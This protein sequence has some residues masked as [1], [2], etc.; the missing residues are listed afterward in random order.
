MKSI[1]ITTFSFILFSSSLFGQST[2]NA[3]EYMDYFSADYATLQADMW[4][5]TRTV[6]HG[7]SARKVEKKRLEMIKTSEIAYKR[8]KA[9][10]DYKG[11][12]E[13]RDTVTEYFRI[14]NLVL[15]EDYSKLVD[16]ED[17][18]EQSYDLMEAYMTA[19]ELASD[20]Q[21]EAAETVSRVQARF[22]KEN[23]ITLLESSDE[24]S[25]KMK[26]AG[27]VYDHYNEVYLIF[28]KSNKQELYLMNAISSGDVNAIEQNREALK[29][30]LEEGYE[31]LKATTPYNGDKTMVE[32]TK[33]I[34]DFYMKEATEGAEIVVNYFLASENFQKTK[35]SFDQIKE[36]SRTQKDID[37]FNE[38]V[39][40]MNEAVN[41]FNKQNTEFNETRSALIDNWN[42][43]AENF[44]HK[45]V[46]RKK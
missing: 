10:S 44:T 27:E 14:I 8:A 17:V 32:A 21:S 43:S 35:N 7:K 33:K 22:A 39:N 31:K 16:M 13:Y 9:A 46:P 5:Y 6:S 42:K 41:T 20:K 38:A 29:S 24:L 18:A 45:H 40:K 3:A 26:I 34:F 15:S 19:R 11:N 25:E 2:T 36:K 12:T 1:I 23:D 28:F 30:T 4:D 37:T